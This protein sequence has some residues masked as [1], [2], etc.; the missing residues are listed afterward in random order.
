M[1]SIFALSALLAILGAGT[2]C[3]TNQPSSTVTATPALSAAGSPGTTAAPAQAPSDEA[4]RVTYGWAVPSRR[5]TVANQVAMPITPPPGIPLPYLVEIRTGDHADF[6]RITFAFHGAFPEY[7]FA[8]G[9]DVQAEGSGMPIELPGNAFLR[10]QFVHA[11]AHDNAG[12][13]TIRFASNE[14]VGLGNLVGYAPAGDFEGYVTYGLGIRVAPNSDQTLEIRVG[15]L[16]R[17]D[18]LYVVAFDVRKG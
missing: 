6:A 15:Q 8:Y 14:A 5:I 16:R 18:G 17:V 2:G 10:I 3:A 12:A 4:Y 11:Q 7:N 1:R 9:P 13:S